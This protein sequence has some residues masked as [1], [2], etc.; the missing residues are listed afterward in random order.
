MHKKV[1][2]SDKYRCLTISYSILSDFKGHFCALL[3]LLLLILIHDQYARGVVVCCEGAV[4]LLAGLLVA[5]LLA[6]L[7]GWLVGWLVGWLLACLVDWLVSWLVVSL[8]TCSLARLLAHLLACFWFAL[9]A[10]F[11]LLCLVDL[12]GLRGWT[13]ETQLN[14]AYGVVRLSFWCSTYLLSLGLA[15]SS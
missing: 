8:L 12:R 10:F 3:L 2:G 11:D 4:T 6:R 5:F 14:D 1:H 13:P 9:L 15:W 7:L